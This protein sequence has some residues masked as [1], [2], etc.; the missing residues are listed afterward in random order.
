MFKLSNKKTRNIILFHLRYVLNIIIAGKIKGEIKYQSK[1]NIYISNRAL[2]QLLLNNNKE[3]YL[4]QQEYDFA[5]KAFEHYIT[6]TKR[7]I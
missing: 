6:E 7:F 5:L 1:I 4:Q 3:K 2:L